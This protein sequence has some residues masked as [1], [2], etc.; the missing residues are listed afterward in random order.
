MQSL[1]NLIETTKD[2][3]WFTRIARIQ[4]EKRLLRNELHAQ[5]LLMTYSIYSITLSV[6]LLKFKIIPDD[7]GTILGIIISITLFGLSFLLN[8][9][10]F[11]ARAQRF[12]ENYI[13]LQTLINQLDLA[14]CTT[15]SDSLKTAI[16]TTQEQYASAISNCENHT[17]TDD[18]IAR[19]LYSNL[20]TRKLSHGEWSYV[21]FHTVARLTLL[22]FL[23]FL[24]LFVFS[25]LILEK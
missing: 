15:D 13:H 21:I 8:S 20:Q 23:Y 5:L 18:Y 6:I 3:I 10:G 24:P 14:L 2:R 12:K 16:K 22:C 9:M 11:S 4:A 7:I 17:T 1:I 19:F 25:Y